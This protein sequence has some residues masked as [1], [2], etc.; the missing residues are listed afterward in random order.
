SNGTNLGKYINYAYD[1]DNRRI[2]AM[3]T[4]ATVTL[5]TPMAATYGLGNQ[6]KKWNGQFLGGFAQG[7]WVDGNGNMGFD[8]ADGVTILTW[9]ERNRLSRA[10]IPGAPTSGFYDFK[11]DDLGRRM[12]VQTTQGSISNESY[13]YD[14]LNVLKTTGANGQP[15]YSVFDGLAL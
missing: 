12:S 6:L 7:P 14:G 2:G 8:P 5:P 10:Y 9:D 4:L 11:Y 13:Q 1:A 3:G 15:S